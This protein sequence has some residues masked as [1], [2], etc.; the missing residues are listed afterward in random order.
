M[1]LHSINA[2][3]DSKYFM[4]RCNYNKEMIV[5]FHLDSLYIASGWGPKVDHQLHLHA[6]VESWIYITSKKLVEVKKEFQKWGYKMDIE[7]NWGFVESKKFQ[8]MS[9]WLREK[10]VGSMYRI[11]HH[12]L[13]DRNGYAIWF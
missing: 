5:T 4:I 12:G 10:I 8:E 1:D 3:T 6:D 2:L 11:I 13:F 7:V 9:Y